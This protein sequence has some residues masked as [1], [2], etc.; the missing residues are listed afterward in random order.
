MK[1]GLMAPVVTLHSQI[2]FPIITSS[3]PKKRVLPEAVSGPRPEPLGAPISW[4]NLELIKAPVAAWYSAL[5]RG[6]EDAV[7]LVRHEQF[8]AHYRDS[9]VVGVVGEPGS[10]EGEVYHRSRQGV[11][12]NH[13][14]VGGMVNILG[15]QREDG[16]SEI[17]DFARELQ[18]YSSVD[19]KVGVDHG[20]RVGVVC[21]NLAIVNLSIENRLRVGGSG[22]DPKRSSTQK[23]CAEGAPQRPRI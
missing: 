9:R 12:A 15:D 5:W 21:G 16:V 14:C 17:F 10:N 8:V 22:E 6:G 7:I 19:D 18:R 11:L 2:A 13:R 3:H 4:M 23:Q 1:L 20:P